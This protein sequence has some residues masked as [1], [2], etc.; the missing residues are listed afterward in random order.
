MLVLSIRV[1]YVVLLLFY[2]YL[3]TILLLEFYLIMNVAVGGTSGWFP[4]GQGNKPWLDK[5]E[6][7]LPIYFSALAHSFLPILY[8]TLDPM[9]DFAKVTPRWYTTWP[10]NVNDRAMVV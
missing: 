1:G 8:V 10:S 3:R 2:S 7:E 9:R 6:S 4:E 5:A